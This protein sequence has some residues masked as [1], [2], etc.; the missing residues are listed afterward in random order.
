MKYKLIETAD[1]D[2]FEYHVNRNLEEGWELYGFTQ[3]EITPVGG[4][5]FF[6]AMIKPRGPKE[7]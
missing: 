5:K 1:H 6:Q 7:E 4:L 2:D 3:V